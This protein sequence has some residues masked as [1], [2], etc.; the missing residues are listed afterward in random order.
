MTI[1][2]ECPSCGKEVKPTVFNHPACEAKCPE[3]DEWFCY[4]D[5]SG[6]TGAA[7]YDGA[8]DQCKREYDGK[9]N[10]RW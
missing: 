7:K 8:T 9:T 5:T 2:A 6:R 1:T 3:C 10:T 4:S